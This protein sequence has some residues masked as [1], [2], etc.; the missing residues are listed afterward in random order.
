MPN[1]CDN[2]V[3]LHNEDKEVFAKLVDTLKIKDGVATCDDFMMQN[4]PLNEEK[5]WEYGAAVEQWGTKWDMNINHI[6]DVGWDENRISIEFYSAWSPPTGFYNTLVSE[7]W[8]V[9]ALYYEPGIGFAGTYLDGEDNE[10]DLSVYDIE[11]YAEDETLSRIDD[12]FCITEYMKEQR[13]EERQEAIYALA[14]KIKEL[15][16]RSLDNLS[17]DLVNISADKAEKLSEFIR[18]ELQ[19]LD[20]RLEESLEARA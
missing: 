12:V 16:T 17:I 2:I 19:D 3:H 15:D 14:L 4:A 18:I 11:D 13:E 8:Y 7:G 6:S 1:W 5:D 9:D 20:V 10:Y